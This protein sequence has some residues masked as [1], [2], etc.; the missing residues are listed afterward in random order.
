MMHFTRFVSICSLTLAAVC[1]AQL[2]GDEPS[3][4]AP[5]L[6]ERYFPELSAVIEAARQNAP[7]TAKYA[8]LEEEAE[9]RLGQARSHRLPNANLYLQTGPRQEFRSGDVEDNSFFVVNGGVQ[10]TQPL[11]HWGAIRAG[12]EQAR[13]A[14]DA[15][16][17]ERLRQETE[18]VR[19]L[20]ADYLQLILAQE[21]LS[22]ETQRL[23][24]I[25]A[26]LQAFKIETEGKKRS[27]IDLQEQRIH[28][29]RAAISIARLRHHE[30]NL[31][32]RI[33]RRS[34]GSRPVVGG[35]PLPELAPA[36]ALE[37][38]Q[39]EEA[40][41]ETG[42]AYDWIPVRQ[43]MAE[44]EQHESQMEIIAANNRP[45]L[46]L[47]LAATQGVTNTATDN[48][49]NTIALT[50]GIGVNWNIFDGFRT[51]NQKIEARLKKNRLKTR[52]DRR[53]AELRSEQR[54][55]IGTLRLRLRELALLERS[56]PIRESRYED[57]E[58][59]REA[60]RI[61][62]ADFQEAAVELENFEIELSQARVDVLLGISD[63][64]SF[65][66]LVETDEP[67]LPPRSTTN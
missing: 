26:R 9:A 24:V 35:G 25:K 29:E 28:A 12:I 51:Q 34:G 13:V 22:Q 23:E 63:Y 20:R 2:K 59:A 55:M 41:L 33:E 47:F 17:L 11:Y 16:G 65:T 62:E 49:V 36:P 4:P 1:G 64:E 27:E 7:L 6:P 58:I 53:V 61:T 3:G 43:R 66:Q 60:G 14:L 54:R 18:L 57:A 50:A 48:D 10:V 38:L 37:W 8:L 39:A 21:R 67:A 32:D 19:Q 56:R 52:L 31:L 42:R 5:Y 30:E 44:L 46:N 15:S 40:T 45:K